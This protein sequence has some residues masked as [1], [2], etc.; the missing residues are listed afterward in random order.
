MYLQLLYKIMSE[1][2]PVASSGLSPPMCNHRLPC[3]ILLQGQEKRNISV[4]GND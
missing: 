1:S 2:L 4:K 3:L